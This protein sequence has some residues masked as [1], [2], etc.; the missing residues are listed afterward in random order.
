MYCY[1]HEWTRKFRPTYEHITYGVSLTDIKE[2]F[3]AKKST[4]QNS[5]GY[6]LCSDNKGDFFYRCIISKWKN[7]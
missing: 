4:R 1:L 7:T 3:R 2:A 6:V 5:F